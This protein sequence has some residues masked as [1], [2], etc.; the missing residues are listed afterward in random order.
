MSNNV[1]IP[2]VSN[3]FKVQVFFDNILNEGDID[4]ELL[5]KAKQDI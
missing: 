4:S 3:I 1:R 2:F 5:S